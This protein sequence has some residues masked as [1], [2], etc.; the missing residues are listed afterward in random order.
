MQVSIET[1]SGLER[2]MTVELPADRFESEVASRL[3]QAA[4]QV[5]LPGFRPGKVPM[6]EVRRRFGAGV[7]QEVAGELMQNS[8]FEAVRAEDVKPAGMPNLEPESLEATDAFRFTAT[9]EVFPEVEIADLS[10]LEVE[11]PTAE[12]TEADI[13]T[14]IERLREQRKEFRAKDGAAGDGDQVTL[15]FTGYL[16]DEA[17]EGG[18]AEDAQI[19]I[20][21]GRMIP[22]F[23]EQLEGTS[24]GDEK[25]F[26]VTF[27]EDYQSEQLAG[28]TVRF[29]VRVKA[30]EESVLPELDDEFF[31]HFGVEEGGMDAFR[32]E[33]R[34]NMER[35]LRNA[36]RTRVKNQVMDGLADLHEI[37]LPEALVHEEVH[38]MQHDMAKQFGGQGMDPHQLPAE[39]FRDQAERRVK[40]GLVLNAL[41]E[42]ESIEPDEARVEELLDDL[43]APYGEPEQVKAWYHQNAEQM[44]Q[45]RSAAVEDQVV[46]HVLERATVQERP[47]TY[48]EI[49]AA[50]QGR[51]PS[52]ADEAAEDTSDAGDDAK[53]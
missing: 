40:I 6:K 22:G 37:V 18:T 14:M 47:S 10:K 9:F 2:R 49:L 4:K 34:R 46:D 11:R 30:V 24:A 16:G 44:Q 50:A 17:F 26:E 42:A 5:R 39:L 7:R 8:F 31:T 53:D 52:E 51:G 15:D 38:R 12:I 35:E 41:V 13:D 45:L 3:K 28:A 32:E 21:S 27:P 1:T 23:E 43:A 20:G 36:Q 33:V 25:S 19:V 29:D 48:D